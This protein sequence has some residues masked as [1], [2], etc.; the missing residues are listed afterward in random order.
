MDNPDTS[1]LPDSVFEAFLDY[2]QGQK[3]NKNDYGWPVCT[4]EYTDKLGVYRK[5]HRESAAELFLLS[6]EKC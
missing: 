4:I 2:L 1:L 5:Y 3:R 6:P